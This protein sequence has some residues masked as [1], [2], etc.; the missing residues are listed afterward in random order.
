MLLLISELPHPRWG[1]TLGPW[2]PSLAPAG[3]GAGIPRGPSSCHQSPERSG[4]QEPVGGR[5]RDAQVIG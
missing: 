5:E 2:K 1:S 4:L 3:D